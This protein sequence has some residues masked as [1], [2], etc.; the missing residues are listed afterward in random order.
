MPR[1]AASWRK[2]KQGTDLCLTHLS[3]QPGPQQ[4]VHVRDK[5]L[6]NRQGSQPALTGAVLTSG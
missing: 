2:L 5:S 6:E 3:Q 4:Y 1:S